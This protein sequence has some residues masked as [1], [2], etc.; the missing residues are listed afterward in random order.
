MNLNPTDSEIERSIAH[1][2]RGNI[3]LYPTDTVWGIGCD[4]RNSEAVAKIYQI[5]ERDV[6]KPM[7]CMV[8]DFDMLKQYV[9]VRPEVETYLSKTTRPTTVIYPEVNGLPSNLLA[10]DGSIA[11]RVVTDSFCTPLIKAFGAP[12]VST[13]ANVSNHPNPSSFEE[14]EDSILERVDYIVNLQ[15]EKKIGPPSRLVRIEEDGSIKILRG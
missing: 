10:I 2:K 14:I 13:S 12:I 11:I 3:I 6:N 9:R 8:S 15:T 7:L 4:A 1:L 5:K